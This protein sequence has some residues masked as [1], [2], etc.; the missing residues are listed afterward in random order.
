MNKWVNEQQIKRAHGQQ[1]KWTTVK[2]KQYKWVPHFVPA[3]K[4]IAP[5]YESKLGWKIN[6]L[7]PWDF[8]SIIQMLKDKCLLIPGLIGI[9]PMD[10]SMVAVPTI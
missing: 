1:S 4:I 3:G 5:E 8:Q 2:A 6:Y 9:R 7:Q 10:I